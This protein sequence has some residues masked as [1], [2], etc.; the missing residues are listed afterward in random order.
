MSVSSTKMAGGLVNATFVGLLWHYNFHALSLGL[1][2]YY[3]LVGFD[4]VL[5]SLSKK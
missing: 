5:G 3:I 4:R 2:T 1:M